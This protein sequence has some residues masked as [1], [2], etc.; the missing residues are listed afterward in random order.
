MLEKF[1]QPYVKLHPHMWS[2]RLSLGEFATN[3]AI[4]VSMSYT[5]FFLN[6][7]ENPALP[8][9]VLI[10]LGSTSNQAVREAMNRMKEALNNVKGSLSKAQEQMKRRMDK[11]K[12]AKEWTVGDRVLLSTRNLQTFAPHLP[13]KLKRRWVG[14][15]TITKIVSLVAFR[16]DLPSWWQIHPSFN[17][18]NLKA[19]IP[20]PEFKQDVEPP[21]PELVDG[22]LE[23][24]VEV[25]L[26]H[27]GKGAWCQHLVSWKGYD[28]LEATW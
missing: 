15:C 14:L 4:N 28:L 23:Y 3:N 26:Q 12:H 18:N 2:K 10:S 13:S 11:A 22:D 21:P 8:E 9:H 7:G 6:G 27:W 25:I 20:H 16:L 1:L 17:A 24:E 5:P 19:Y